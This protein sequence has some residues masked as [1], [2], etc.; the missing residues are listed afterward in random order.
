MGELFLSSISAMIQ[1]RETPKTHRAFNNYARFFDANREFRDLVNHVLSV[2]SSIEYDQ[3][4]AL[5]KL[6]NKK[7]YPEVDEYLGANLIKQLRKSLKTKT[8]MQPHDD[9]NSSISMESSSVC[10]EQVADAE[11]KSSCSS[12][13]DDQTLTEL[14]IENDRLLKLLSENKQL[15]LTLVEDGWKPFIKLL[16]EK[17][18]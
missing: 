6:L 4:E 2:D 8:V 13:K 12:T 16:I 1:S 9:D 18:M 5:Q 10:G 3:K 11:N 17:K 14:R 15:L 7:R